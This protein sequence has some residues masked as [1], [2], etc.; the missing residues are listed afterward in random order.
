MKLEVKGFQ[1]LTHFVD[2]NKFPGSLSIICIFSNKELLEKVR[3]KMKDQFIRELIQIEL[4]QINTKFKN[5]N[6]RI[7]FNTENGFKSAQNKLN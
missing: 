3:E 1:W 7:L 4:E 6:Q 5:I 2:Y